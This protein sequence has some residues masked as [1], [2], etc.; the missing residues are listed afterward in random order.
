MSSMYAQY[1]KEREDV[2]TYEDERGFFTYQVS[3]DSFHVVDLFILPKFRNNGVGKEYSDK[4]EELAKESNCKQTFCST[5]TQALNWKQ[6]NKYIL[7][8]NYKKIKEVGVMV[9][10]IKEL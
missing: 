9:Y 5:C 7:S 3:N 1:I 10:Y 6:S 8:N 2:D 4:I